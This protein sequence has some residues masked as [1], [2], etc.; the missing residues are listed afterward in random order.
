MLAMQKNRPGKEGMEI[1]HVAEP[2]PGPGEVRLQVAAGGVC[3]TDLHIYNGVPE[4]ARLLKLPVVLGHEISGV[5]NA[6]G[7]GVERVKVGDL[8]SLESHIPCGACYPCRLGRTHI[9]RN[10]RY[11]GVTRDGGFAEQ[12]VVPEQIAWVHPPTVDL[13]VAAMF[14]PFGIAVHAGLE[15]RG[16]AGQNVMITGCGP[17]GL[18]SIAVARALGAQLIL[19]TDINPTR[20]ALAE[21]MG[22]DRVID[23]RTEDPVAIARDCTHGDGLDVVME[24]SGQGSALLQG[25]E[26][27]VPGGDLRLVG[28]ASGPV[29]LD[30]TRWV[31]K[32][33]RVQS[34]HGRKLFESWEVAG[35]LVYNNRVNIRPLISHMIPLRESLRVFDLIEQG[36]AVK[37]LIMPEG[38][39]N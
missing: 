26:A 35:R 36:E 15:G 37:V 3:G 23:V 17:I 31:L 1:V 39:G 16:V 20:L 30:I 29:T 12:V 4:I 28:A 22:A 2:H 6:V 14:E 32:G 18:M 13:H 8:V 7:S 21:Q 19:A 5:V 11:P 27:L 38:R 25:V 24:Y 33:I 9:C 10:T 34:I